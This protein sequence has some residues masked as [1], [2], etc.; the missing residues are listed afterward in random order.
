MLAL[1][2]LVRRLGR[3][4][5][6]SIAIFAA[7]SR[8]IATPIAAPKNFFSKRLFL[9]RRSPATRRA[10]PLP[11]RSTSTDCGRRSS[12][13]ALSATQSP[14]IVITVADRVAD[15][16]GLWPAD[17]ELLTKLPQLTQSTSSAP[18]SLLG[19][20]LPRTASWRASRAAGGTTR[21]PPSGATAVARRASLAGQVGRGL[22]FSYRDR[23]D[24]L[25]ACRSGSRRSSAVIAGGDAPATAK[26]RCCT[27]R[28]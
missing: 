10:W 20:G 26:R 1:Y 23:E 16:D 11:E 3:A 18:K 5:P 28:R 14:R 6:T 19:A 15:P 2:D 25:A 17:Y 4:W 24:E 7:S 27:A 21:G 13:Q 12:D 9:R 22:V 8:R